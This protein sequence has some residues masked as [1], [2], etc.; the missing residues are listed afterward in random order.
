MHAD[1]WDED[2]EERELRERK[3]V[4]LPFPGNWVNFPGKS[5]FMELSFS[6]LQRTEEI[7]HLI[8][9]GQ[10]IYDSEKYITYRQI[11]EI[12]INNLTTVI[13]TC[14]FTYLHVSKKKKKI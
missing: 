10:S 3:R 9:N 12:K 8:L 4:F 2:D 14:H 1:Y 13:N 11:C 6:R 7:E 5:F